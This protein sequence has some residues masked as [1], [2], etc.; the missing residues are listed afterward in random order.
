V[1]Q[2]LNKEGNQSW[3]CEPQCSKTTD[4]LPFDG[5]MCKWYW[6]FLKTKNYILLA[7]D[8]KLQLRLLW[9]GQSTP[10]CRTDK[11]TASIFVP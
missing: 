7:E 1:I 11:N 9:A 8:S 5:R 6:I 4:I 3:H 2:G 10:S